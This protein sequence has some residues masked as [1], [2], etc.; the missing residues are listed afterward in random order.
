MN[1]GKRLLPKCLRLRVTLLF[2]AASIN[3]NAEVPPI[4][5]EHAYPYPTGSWLQAAAWGP[6]GFV[7]VGFQGEMLFSAD[8]IQWENT[9]TKGPGVPWFSGVCYY[10]GRYVGVGGNLVVTSTNGRDWAVGTSQQ[11]SLL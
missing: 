4:N 3:L 10:D 1:S 9:N 8:G 5:W 6:L 11:R 2:L 7:T